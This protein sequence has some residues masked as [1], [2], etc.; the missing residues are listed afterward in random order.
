M[1]SF[2]SPTP[3][4]FTAPEGGVV[5]D[6]PVWI[7]GTVVIPN[8]DADEGEEFVGFTDGT[9][10]LPKHAEA[11]NYLFATGDDVYWDPDEAECT[12]IE[13]GYRVGRAFSGALST[14]TTVEVTLPGPGARSLIDRK[15]L[16]CY[17]NDS[18]ASDGRA[19]M[20]CQA[21]EATILA[22][23]TEGAA[24]ISLA[25]TGGDGDRIIV[26]HNADPAANLG[27]RQVYFDEDAPAHQRLLFV[28]A[29]S[30]D[31]HVVTL[32]GRVLTIKHDADAA[33]KGVAL[34]LDDA[35]DHVEFVSPTNTS[36][37]AY[38]SGARHGHGIAFGR[39]S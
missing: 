34:Y 6:R 13:T 3:R 36:G 30:V 39:A 24:N 28:S 35:D 1:K 12:T 16:P 14:A 29:H 8:A 4:T 20:V 18:A 38:T 27:G 10:E 9:F 22:N 21:P 31:A 15:V 33:T 7:G 32:G 19:L 17:D 25:L 23:N 26:R 2:R 5:A 11:N 37:S